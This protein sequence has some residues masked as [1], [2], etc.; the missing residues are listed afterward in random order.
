M[1]K[2]PE[3]KGEEGRKLEVS[4]S[5]PLCYCHVSM[6]TRICM[7]M[8]FFSN[9]NLQFYPIRHST[10]YLSMCHLATHLGLFPG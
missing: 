7:H 6:H 8:L 10:A 9:P 5:L 1:F 2:A 3:S 4:H